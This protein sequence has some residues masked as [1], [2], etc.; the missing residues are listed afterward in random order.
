VPMFFAAAYAGTCRR[1]HFRTRQRG[2]VERTQ[3]SE[4]QGCCRDCC[5]LD[6][7]GRLSTD[8]GGAHCDAAGAR[9]DQAYRTTRLL[10]SG[11][12]AATSHWERAANRFE[13]EPLATAQSVLLSDSDQAVKA[14]RA[15]NL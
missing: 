5:R 7:A 6:R 15:M 4:Q 2:S 13:R 12:D 10:L 1:E 14:G 8:C 9:T 11:A 3:P